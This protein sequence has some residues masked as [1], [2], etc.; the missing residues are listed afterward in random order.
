MDIWWDRKKAVNLG[1]YTKDEVEDLTGC[2]PLFL[3][4]C[5]VGDAIDLTTTFFQR[6]AEQAQKFEMAIPKRCSDDELRM[7]STLILPT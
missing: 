3:D 7:Y 1:N 5:V 2:I 6:C 4:K